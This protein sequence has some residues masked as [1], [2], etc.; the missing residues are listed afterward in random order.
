MEGGLKPADIALLYRAEGPTKWVTKLADELRKSVPVYLW[1][2]RE[3]F[4]PEPPRKSVWLSTMHAAKGL[5][6]KAVFILKPE[7]MPMIGRDDAQRDDIEGAERNLMYVALTRPEQRL[8][9]VY[10]Q[11]SGFAGA[12]LKT[13]DRA[14]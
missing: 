14:T 2:P 13:C 5:Q 6:W 11:P 9:I 12:L 1:N 3:R 4:D 10:A 7:Q 8:F